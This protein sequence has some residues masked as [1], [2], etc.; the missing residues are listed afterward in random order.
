MNTDILFE[1]TETDHWSIQ[2]SSVC[3]RT[4]STMGLN[5]CICITISSGCTNGKSMTKPFW[6]Q[7]PIFMPNFCSNLNQTVPLGNRGRDFWDNKQW[8]WLPTMSFSKIT[9]TKEAEVQNGKV[10]LLPYL[11][12][13]CKCTMGC[14]LDSSGL[15]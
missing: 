1:Y 13:L 8:K 12:V 3:T 14:S 11:G 2:F 6:L 7:P 9:R 15:Q 4:G 5:Q 10:L